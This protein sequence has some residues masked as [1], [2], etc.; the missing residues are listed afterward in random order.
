MA[1]II[2]TQEISYEVSAEQIAKLFCQLD[3]EEMADFFNT[4]HKI[5]KEEWQAPFCFQLQFVS[6]S[7]VLT[8]EGKAIM[9]EIGD[10]GK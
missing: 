7:P 4:I 6:D 5:V 9:C 8:P 10:Y 3:G 2:T 1:K